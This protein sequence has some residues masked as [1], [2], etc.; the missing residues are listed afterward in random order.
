M[1]ALIIYGTRF[2]WTQK[3][4]NTIAQ[5]LIKEGYE[6]EV[7]QKLNKRQKA[8]ISEYDLLIA[9]SS[10]VSGMWKSGIKKF[11]KKYGP[12]V[13]RLCIFVTSAGTLHYSMKNG[14]TFEQAR[15]K[16][17]QKYISPLVSRYNL[18]AFKTGIFG[19]QNGKGDNIK[20]NNWDEEQVRQW[21]SSLVN[22]SKEYN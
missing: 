22:D 7:A 21:I 2:G 13:R 6:V 15:D 14:M 3:T 4:V 16:A 9:G 10:I 18:N 17:L 12:K 20:Y 1:K 8:K 19:G 11:L 5:D